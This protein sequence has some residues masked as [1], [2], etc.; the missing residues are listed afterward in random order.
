MWMGYAAWKKSDGAAPTLGDDSD[1][2]SEGGHSITSSDGEQVQTEMA[3]LRDE[4]E[5]IRRKAGNTFQP[6]PQPETSDNSSDEGCGLFGNKTQ[7]TDAVNLLM[8]RLKEHEQIAVSDSAGQR[9]LP[10]HMAEPPSPKAAHPAF[11]SERLQEALRDH[12]SKV[13]DQLKS[14][15]KETEWAMPANITE[16]VDPH[17]LVQM[18]SPHPSAEKMAQAWIQEKQLERNHITHE[19]ILLALVLDRSLM[20][21]TGFVNSQTC[22]IVCRRVYALKKAFEAVKSTADWKQPKGAASSK[23]K[24]KVR[25]DIANEIDLRALVGETDSI[26]E[27]DRELQARLKDKALMSK[28]IETSTGSAKEEDD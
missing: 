12:R 25:W 17:L 10:S 9:P 24:S 28:W 1:T 8:N 3:R 19:I 27:V 21:D 2:E 11:N 14:Y 13:L 4:I 6:E 20:E 5:I 22:E 16:R 7:M 23:W 26:P 15:K 18:F